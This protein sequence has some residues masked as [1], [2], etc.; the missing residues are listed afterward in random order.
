ML[1]RQILTSFLYLASNNRMKISIFELYRQQDRV[2]NNFANLS[3]KHSLRYIGQM[4]ENPYLTD[5]LICLDKMKIGLNNLLM[6]NTYFLDDKYK[7]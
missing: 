6:N 7:V 2:Q 4:I 3:I 1:L 5:E